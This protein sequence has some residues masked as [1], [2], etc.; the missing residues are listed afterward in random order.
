MRVFIT[1]SRKFPD[2]LMVRRFVRSLP[3]NAIILG[4]TEWGPSQAALEEAALMHYKVMIRC[5]D[6][7]D[8]HTPGAKV[9]TTG[10]GR[11][12]NVRAGVAIDHVH[13]ADADVAVIFWDGTPDETFQLISH[14]KTTRTPLHIVKPKETPPSLV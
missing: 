5:P 14:A 11:C 7:Y 12:I 8:L 4:R 13:L 1:G 9:R 3:K 2:L 10:D 6:W